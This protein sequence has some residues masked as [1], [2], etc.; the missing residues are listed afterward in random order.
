MG[1]VWGNREDV[2]VAASDELEIDESSVRGSPDIG[3]ESVVRIVFLEVAFES[4][5]RAARQK[6]CGVLAGFVAKA[7]HGLS[8]IFRFGRIDAEKPNSL[9][10]VANAHIDRVAIDD[11]DHCWFGRVR[12]V[13]VLGNG[14]QQHEEQ[15]ERSHKEQHT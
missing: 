11:I 7:L 1:G 5:D 10:Q 13:V 12:R 8:G 6:R 3:Q 2:G 4:N 9:T 14:A 15:K